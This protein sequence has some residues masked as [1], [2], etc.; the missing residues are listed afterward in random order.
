MWTFLWHTLFFDPIYNGLIFL[1]E[2]LPGKDVGLAVILLTVFVKV[3]LLPLS[4]KAA[5]TQHAMR[6]LEPVLA[7]IKEEY[8]DKKEEVAKRTM[9]AYK[10]AGINPFASI[11]LALVQIPVVIALYLAV[12]RGGGIH[13]PAINTA[14]LYPFVVPDG[15]LSMHLF[16]IIDV[17]S[18]SMFLAL[19]AGALQYFYGHLSLPPVKQKTEETPN[20]KEDLARSMQ[21]QMKYM[22]PIIITFVAYSTSAVIAV[23]FVVSNLMS[24]VQEYI[25][26]S[27]IPDRHSDPA[28]TKVN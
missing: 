6:S 13:L 7:R 5:H 17:A 11:L 4:L 2:H 24:L 27:Q 22:M 21:L 28:Q 20:F 25:L 10:E 12:S 3:V 14:L 16:G 23:Y 15:V 8:K 19:L 1:A 9:A 18:K 26:R